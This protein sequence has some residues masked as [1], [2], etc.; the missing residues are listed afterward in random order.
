[1]RLESLL[2]LLCLSHTAAAGGE[3]VQVDEQLTV[4][5]D[6]W[7]EVRAL[8][9]LVVDQRAELNVLKTRLTSSESEL[10][11]LRGQL[12]TLSTNTERSKVAF[13]AALTDSGLLG[14]FNTDTTIVYSNVFTNIGKAYN[15]ITGIF[16]APVKGVYYFRFTGMDYRSAVHMG[17]ALYKNNQR[18]MLTYE[19]N[20]NNG[21][22]EHM[23]N[24]VT[25]E[26]EKGDVVF[27][28]LPA[29]KG[30]YDNNESHNTFSGFL[31]FTL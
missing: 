4:Q 18:I 11:E 26:L 20:V 19:I 12:Q 27:L 21:Y 24:G 8:R 6:V 5:P 10:Q 22:F 23:S 13:S 14:P 15:P 9:H 29:N 16:T 28:R 2:L 17:A 25:L 31:L 30:L 7:A 3:A 1:M